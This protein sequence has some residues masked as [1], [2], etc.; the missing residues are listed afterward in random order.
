MPC[1]DALPEK[2][3][4]VS[5]LKSLT[6]THIISFEEAFEIDGKLAI[7]ME[8]ASNGDLLKKV[9]ESKKAGELIK[10][11][12]IIQWMKQIS[13]AMKY[14]LEKKVIHRDIKI[15]NILLDEYNNVLISH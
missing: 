13:L 12:Q 2:C 11:E 15:Q 3:L 4:E 14:L 5:L 7:V 1:Q 10:E 8:Y 6:H 9:N